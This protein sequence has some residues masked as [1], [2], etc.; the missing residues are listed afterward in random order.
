MISLATPQT[1]LLQKQ[2]GEGLTVVAELD[3]PHKWEGL[4]DV[5]VE[6]LDHDEL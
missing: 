6:L 3:F 2:I 5:S 4:V 1:A